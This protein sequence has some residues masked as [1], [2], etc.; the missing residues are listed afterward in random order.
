MLTSH[1]R[2][3]SDPRRFAVPTKAAILSSLI[4]ARIRPLGVAGK[5]V[6]KP[7]GAELLIG[8]SRQRMNPGLW[9]VVSRR[10]ST[11]DLGNSVVSV[12]DVS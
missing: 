5:G 1:S 12:S 10:V 9:Q 2:S 6:M 3:Q 11:N 4:T 7:F 8:N